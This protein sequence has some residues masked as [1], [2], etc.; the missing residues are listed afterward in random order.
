MNRKLTPYLLE[1][2]ENQFRSYTDFQMGVIGCLFLIFQILIR[3]A[4]EADRNAD[5]YRMDFSK[6]KPAIDA[7]INH[8]EQKI[9]ITTAAEKCCLSESHFMKI[10]KKITGKSFNEFLIEHRL[11]MASQ[12]LKDTD[13]RLIDIA[14]SSGFYNQSYFT[15][16]FIRYYS[17]TPSEYRKLHQNTTAPTDAGPAE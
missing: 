5:E 15:R 11:N 9:S 13:D 3:Y 1:L 6:V 10:F 16:M 14:N 17:M 8:Y 12:M 4:V 7:V 2:I